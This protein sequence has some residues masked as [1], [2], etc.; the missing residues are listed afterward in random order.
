MYQKW[1]ID[2]HIKYVDNHKSKFFN[3]NKEMKEKRSR[4]VVD[5]ISDE[6]MIVRVNQNAEQHWEQRSKEQTADVNMK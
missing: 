6:G 1:H 4:C 3:N 5:G 2:S